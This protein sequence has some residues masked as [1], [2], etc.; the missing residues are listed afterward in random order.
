MT[1]ESKK[2]R[3]TQGHARMWPRHVFERPELRDGSKS[4]SML[5]KQLEFLSKPGVYVLYRDD[6]PY[7]IGQSYRLRRRLWKWAKDPRS[8]YYHFWNFFTAFTVEDS[9]L[10]D[11]LEGILIACMPTANSM[12]PKLEHEPMPKE[13]CELLRKMYR[14]K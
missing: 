14:E 7:Y 10:R 3:I 9:K 12:R 4:K 8:R 11:E 1:G 6:E 5:A 2:G 13:V